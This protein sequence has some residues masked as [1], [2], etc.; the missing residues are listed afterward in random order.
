M[1]I[2]KTIAILLFSISFAAQSSFRGMNRT[3]ILNGPIPMAF[4]N[5]ISETYEIPLSQLNAQR[6]LYLIITPENMEQYLDELV[7][8]KKSQGFDVIVKTLS[9]TGPTADDIKSS[10]AATLSADPM[11]EYVLLIG[12]VDG[13]ATMPSFYYGPDN[14]VTD[15]KYTHLL[16]NDFFPDVFIGRFSVD[17]IAE[18]VVMIR[19]T[20]NYHRQPLASNPDWL[21]K[22]LIVAGNYSNTVP[23]PITPKWTSY[24]IR[25]LLLDEGYSSVD[26]V[27]YPPTQQG[28]SMIQNIINSGVGIVNYRGWG[29]ANGWHYPEFHVSDVA[30]LNNGWM[31]PVFTSFV[32]NSNDFAN[33]VDPCLGEALIRAGT[34]SNPKGGVAIVGPSDLHTSTK[35]NNIINAYMFDAMLDEGI[36]E[37]APAVNAG[38]LGLVDE[39]PNL[40][41]PGEAQE[42]YF[43]VYNIVGDP[44]LA[45][46]LTEPKEFSVYTNTLY[47][48]DG[49]IL[50]RVKDQY[51]NRIPDAIV[52]IM[53][54]DSV[55]AKGISNQI[56][57]FHVSVSLNNITSVDVYV[58]K[59]GFIQYHEEIATES[60]DIELMLIGYELQ[61]DS[62]GNGILETGETV[63]VYPIFKNSGHTA[64]NST[65]ADIEGVYCQVINGNT[66]IPEADNDEIVMPSTPI[67]IRSNSKDY[68]HVSLFIDTDFADYT[69]YIPVVKPQLDVS[70]GPNDL[71]P[72]SDFTPELTYH[73]YSSGQFNNVSW[74]FTN[75]NE[76]VSCTITDSTVYF[77]IEPF[78]SQT[79]SLDDHFCSLSDSIS[80]GSDLTFNIQIHQDTVTLYENE[81]EFNISSQSTE[82]PVTNTW[83]GYWAYDDTDTNYTQSPNFDWVELDPVFG[84][85]GG[86]EYKLDDDDHV[87]VDLPFEFKYFDQIYNE[88]TISSNGWTSFIPCNI[89][90]FYNYTIPMAMGPKALLAP[91]WD[92]L[93]VIND[94]SIRVYTKHDEENGRFI[95]EWS[96]AL[97]GFDETTEETFAIHLYDQTAMPTESG[98]G[99]IEFHYLDVADID[100]D[101]NYATVGIED[102]TKN[103]GIQYVFNNGYAPGAAELSNE[104]AIRFTTEA[105]ANYV[106]PLGTEE[107]NLPTGFQLLPAY[108]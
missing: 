24:W 14:D 10:I 41:G 77:D 67:T 75:Q 104:R 15:Q 51:E 35:Y 102:H 40:S 55:I 108:P 94:D 92:D 17:S 19:K 49:D 32:C 69:L 50:I 84:G 76:L 39:F 80:I 4:S 74:S 103:E 101:K 85:S 64:T 100:A 44:S 37:L 62:N 56:G 73:N 89:D 70:V 29:D 48:H 45:M 61:N 99:M 68:D 107:E 43:H 31:T 86:T 106:A 88:I 27:F 33:N 63:D 105:P 82:D 65:T 60:L 47:R 16:G 11:L 58:N 53:S 71:E 22:A 9:E 83:Y 52:S 98:D 90:Y 2:F 54:G 79:I 87:N 42:F 57:Y 93:E 7:S 38:L 21:D 3:D 12:D 20:I 1:R 23:I 36:V 26:T 25:N 78:T 34:P 30:G 91:F 5:I 59:N 97:N 81:V 46:H 8:F 72:N 96:R 66:S 18:L 95:I 28:A 13:V 6:G